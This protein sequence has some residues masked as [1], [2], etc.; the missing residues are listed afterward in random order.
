MTIEVDGVSVAIGVDPYMRMYVGKGPNDRVEV[1]L[2]F[3]PATKELESMRDDEGVAVEDGQ[4]RPPR[5]A[6]SDVIEAV[7]KFVERDRVRR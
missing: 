4:R 1:P 3:N 6:V 5:S 7:L 2:A